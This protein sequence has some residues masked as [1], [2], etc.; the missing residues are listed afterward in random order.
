MQQALGRARTGVYVLAPS[1]WALRDA[2]DS[3]TNPRARGTRTDSTGAMHAVGAGQPYTRAYTQL[4]S[5]PY[6]L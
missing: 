1:S 3:C 6:T 4:Y 2:F 5:V